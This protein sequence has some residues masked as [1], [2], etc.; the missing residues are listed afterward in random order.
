MVEKKGKREGNNKKEQAQY[1]LQ[2]AN[3]QHKSHNENNRKM[4]RINLIEKAYHHVREAMLFLEP[5]AHQN[6]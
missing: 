1:F 5:P 6:H 3:P 2:L 4:L